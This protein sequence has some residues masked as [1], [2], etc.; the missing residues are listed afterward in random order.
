[1]LKLQ[2]IQNQAL[3]WIHPWEPYNA[4]TTNETLHRIYKIPPINIR[5]HQLAKKVWDK[6]ANHQDPNL[7][8]IQLKEETLEN[9]QEHLWFPRSRPRARGNPPLPIFK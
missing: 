3:R 9:D 8:N 2:T 4:R 6:L 5:L 1:M 7:I